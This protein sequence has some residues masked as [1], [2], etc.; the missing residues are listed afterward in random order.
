M[1][2]P[3]RKRSPTP[4]RIFDTAELK[5]LQ[6]QD[7]VSALVRSDAQARATI[8]EV[9]KLVTQAPHKEKSAYLANLLIQLG[10][11]TPVVLAGALFYAD[12][13]TEDELAQFED[14]SVLKLVTALDRMA[15]ADDVAETSAP[16]LDR[17]SRD[18]RKN[19]RHML[20]ALIDDPRVA[21]LKLAER[22]V[23][24][25]FAKQQEE[26][27]RKKIAKEV[28]EFYCALASRLGVW[29]LKWMLEDL[30]FSY[31]HPTD[32]RAIVAGLK[33]RRVQREKQ[34]EAVREDL[35]WR[36][37]R[38]SL[39]TEVSGRAKNVYGIWRKMSEKKISF[40]T[41]YDVEAV[42]VIVNDVADC[43]AV[44]GVVH[45]S[46]PA[47]SDAFDDYI[48]NPKANGYRSLH[49]AVVGP[50]GRNL[51][52]QIRTHKMHEEAE[53]GVCAHWA[54]KDD[55]EAFKMGKID[56]MREVLHWQDE[57]YSENLFIDFTRRLEAPESIYI[58][59]PKGHVIDLP[60]GSTAVDF[61]Y[62]IHTDIG[63][64]CFGVKINGHQ[65]PL[66]KPLETGQVVE[67][68]TSPRTT[69]R[70]HWLDEE[71][72]YVR[73]SRV[74]K[75]IQ[76]YFREERAET[77][78]QAGKAWLEDECRRLKIEVNMDSLAHSFNYTNVDEMY[79]AVAVG[80]Q[81][82][83]ELLPMRLLS[84]AAADSDV[85]QPE[86]EQ[87]S[88]IVQE[89]DVFA[90][91][92]PQ[93][94]LDITRALAAMSINVV[95]AHIDSPVTGEPALLRLKVEIEGL[96]NMRNVINRLRAVPDVIDVKRHDE[97]TASK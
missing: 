10:V 95:G 50:R 96:E 78:A 1:F 19:V 8:L 94:L 75:S 84:T 7:W 56:W 83:R 86:I 42:R 70:R 85:E 91:D 71:L 73:T 49:T 44:L 46:W 17:Q 4:K 74:R 2:S 93:L 53:F 58:S 48:A 92:R 36:L 65:Q 6:T 13:E 11:D 60:A 68:L 62:R 72:G 79:I 40:D 81:P 69:P 88:K 5:K 82:V 47:I 76:N 14:A 52:V 54:Y 22:L 20:I 80:D 37:S 31:L 67:I 43:Y 34:V 87:S 64:H 29:Q 45:T 9:E 18:H 61:A 15:Q 55:D 77:N 26:K 30:A 90:T 32:Y 28:M 66:N 97:E 59:T 25:Q 21:V 63:N 51:E 12:R 24:M 57:M 39:K 35:Q 33:E 41:V 38:Q 27:Y 3:L 16:F 23:A 89:L